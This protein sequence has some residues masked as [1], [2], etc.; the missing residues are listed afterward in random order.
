MPSASRIDA[1]S[2]S[3][4][5]AFSS[6]TVACAAIPSRRC[7]R[8]C[9]KRLYVSVV[10]SAQVRKVLLHQVKRVRQI[11]RSPDFERRNLA[12]V[13][14]RPLVCFG[15]PVRRPAQAFEVREEA[16][17][18][19]PERR[20][21]EGCLAGSDDPPDEPRLDLDARACSAGWRL[22][23]HR[24]GTWARSGRKL[25]HEGGDVAATEDRVGGRNDERRRRPRGESARDGVCRAV[26]PRLP[27]E[28]EFGSESRTGEERLDL[29]REVPDDDGHG[30]ATSRSQLADDGHDD[31]PAADRKYGLGPAV[32]ERA[33]APALA[34]RHHDRLHYPV[35]PSERRETRPSVRS[36]RESARRSSRRSSRRSAR[37]ERRASRVAP[38][39]PYRDAAAARAKPEP[40]TPSSCSTIAA[41]SW[42]VALGGTAAP[43][44]A[45]KS[46][47]S[48]T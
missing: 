25:A 31:R 43:W 11:T 5:F 21:G 33:Q 36:V 47:S 37:S 10:A 19:R 14:D 41:S 46:S 6:G 13:V 28:R 20:M 44:S 4:R 9:W 12:T 39:G 40:G 42:R 45:T 8:P 2:G 18:E 24:N 3:R 29:L 27:R 48:R 34:G 17:A 15:E 23:S 38:G 22:A 30:R 32:R 16:F 1:L 26:R 7:A 35:R